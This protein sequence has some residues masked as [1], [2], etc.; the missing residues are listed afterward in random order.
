MQFFSLLLILL[1]ASSSLKSLWF[2]GRNN[3]CV[4]QPI[5]WYCTMI[6]LEIFQYLF[7]VKMID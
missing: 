7:V 3:G 2:S 4:T 5:Q 6:Y 1:R